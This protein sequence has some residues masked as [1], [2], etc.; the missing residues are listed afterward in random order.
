MSIE[1]FLPNGKLKHEDRPYTILPNHV[2][3]N[4][5]NLEALGLWCH[6]QSRPANWD[7]SPKNIQIHF[8]IGR[9]KSYNLLHYLID[10]GL[11]E[12]IREKHE[13]GTFGASFYIVKN[14]DVMKNY[15]P[16]PKK[17]K[18]VKSCVDNSITPFPDLPYPDKPYPV[19][20][21]T[22]NTR[23]SKKT[24]EIKKTRTRPVPVF[25]DSVSVQS[26]IQHLV[27]QRQLELDAAIVS[28]GT[29]YAWDTNS[30]KGISSVVKR[31]NIFLKKVREGQW[32]IPQGYNGITSQS[33]REKEE[34]QQKA[35]KAEYAQDVAAIK[36]LMNLKECPE[37]QAML[38]KVKGRANGA[39]S[40]RMQKDAHQNLD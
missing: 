16:S 5:S 35:K 29:Y 13:D 17:P 20:Q 40:G 24:R 32:L 39:Y 27:A 8:N 2:L 28:Q 38:K 30:D 23:A 11:L 1:K 21:D 6:L 19:N 7:V 37:F 15:S 10:V 12:H 26:H 25:S 3:Q 36:N 33:I 31:I 9:D 14:G 4:C 18:L 22:T 34:L